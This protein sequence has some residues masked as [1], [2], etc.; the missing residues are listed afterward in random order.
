MPLRLRKVFIGM[1]DFQVA[2][3]T[4]T[5]GS[6]TALGGSRTDARL[7]EGSSVH[8]AGTTAAFVGA[9]AKQGSGSAF[10]NGDSKALRQPSEGPSERRPWVAHRK[11]QDTGPTR[12]PRGPEQGAESVCSG[13]TTWGP[14]SRE[15]PWASS[16]PGWQQKERLDPPPAPLGSSGSAWPAPSSPMKEH[17][18]R[19]DETAANLAAIHHSS[20]H[21][22]SACR[23]TICEPPGSSLLAGCSADPRAMVLERADIV[24]GK[25]APRSRWPWQVSLRVHVEYWMYFCGGSL[26]H[27]Q[28]VL[29]TVHCLGPDF[30]DPGTL[31]VQLR[32]Q[33]LYYHDWLLPV[34][35]VI[36]HPNFY[37]VQKGA[38]I[39]LLELEDPVNIS[40]HVQL[41]TLPPASETFP[42]GTL[43]WVTSWG[44]VGNNVQLPPFP[45]KEVEVPIVENSLCDTEYHS[46]M[47]TGDNI[48]IVHDDM[49]CTGNEGHDSCQGDSG[50]PL[51]CKVNGT[52]MQAGVVSWGDG[53]AQPNRPG[54]YTRVTHYSDW[55]R[56]YVPTEP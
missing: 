6:L 37:S 48:R 12:E 46:G 4:R 45:L 30:T 16:P 56:R 25:E 42:L 22:T 50:G 53:C 10:Q 2:G 54:I 31:R 26:V 14:S 17:P 8:S 35:R 7:L 5:P 38:D 19:G 55:I 3:E 27:P 33:H 40:G 9:C 18:E 49:L 20:T 43:C 15:D 13:L 34:S 23:E 39:A 41:V 44:D 28:W 21:P 1:L 29:T 52:W 47:Y 51:V 11:R 32:E 24:Q 36:V